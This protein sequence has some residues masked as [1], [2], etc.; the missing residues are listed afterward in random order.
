MNDDDVSTN[1]DKV[2]EFHTTANKCSNSMLSLIPLTLQFHKWLPIA[3]QYS[4]SC[5]VRGGG[6]S[7]VSGHAP[8]SRVELSAA[9]DSP[10][11]AEAADDVFVATQHR[12][13]HA[14]PPPVVGR[15]RRLRTTTNERGARCSWAGAA[16]SS[17]SGQYGTGSD[18][19]SDCG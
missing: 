9:R 2:Q 4:R 15:P 12:L 18:T 13:H 14:R 6:A 17:A 5:L 16:P 11:G 1:H 19:A 7:T 10:A 3:N 8:I